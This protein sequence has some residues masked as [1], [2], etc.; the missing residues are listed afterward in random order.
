M[1]S[2]PEP[3]DAE[4][5]TKALPL[6]VVTS[7]LLDLVIRPTTSSIDITSVYVVEEALASFLAVNLE[8][9][10][11]GDNKSVLLEEVDVVVRALRF[12]IRRELQMTGSVLNNTLNS[13]SAPS[14]APTAIPRDSVI[15][16]ANDE[17]GYQ[18]STILTT[19]VSAKF[20]GH[21]G[22]VSLSPSSP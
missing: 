6:L 21:P 10:F 7:S 16:D 1:S 11:N 15:D 8:D 20:R 5:E 22:D 18:P 2:G 17:G 3:P 19:S 4:V 9:R 14:V 13:S 12:D